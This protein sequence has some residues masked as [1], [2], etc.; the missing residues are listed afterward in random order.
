MGGVGDLF[1]PLVHV[2]WGIFGQMATRATRHF[3]DPD[4]SWYLLAFSETE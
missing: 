2:D 3:S 1:C 4:P